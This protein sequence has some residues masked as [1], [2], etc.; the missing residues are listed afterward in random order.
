MIWGKQS[1]IEASKT[2]E[3]KQKEYEAFIF[4][5]NKK[6]AVLKRKQAVENKKQAVLK[7]KQAVLKRKQAIEKEKQEAWKKIIKMMNSI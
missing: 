2:P 1:D 5:E 3:Q 4:E 7:R 6:Q